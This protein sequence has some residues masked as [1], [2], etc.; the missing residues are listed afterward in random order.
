MSSHSR[1]RFMLATSKDDS[2]LRAFLRENPVPGNIEVSFEREPDFFAG[3]AIRG[4]LHQTILVR[5]TE[6]GRIAGM[7]SRSISKAFVN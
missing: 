4:E 6:T 5:D 3:S 1:F 2:A 7:G